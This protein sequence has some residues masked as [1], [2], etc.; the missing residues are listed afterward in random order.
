MIFLIM[1]TTTYENGYPFAERQCVKTLAIAA[2]EGAGLA[3]KGALYPVSSVGGFPRTNRARDGM[4][5]GSPHA[6]HVPENDL[7]Y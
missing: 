3:V 7:T 1:F 5:S 4:T 6:Q 2:V